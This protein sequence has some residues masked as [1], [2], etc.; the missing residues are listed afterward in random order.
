[1]KVGDRIGE[2]EVCSSA[3]RGARWLDLSATDPNGIIEAMWGVWVRPAWCPQCKGM[4]GATG[5]GGL[6]GNS[7]DPCH[8]GPY[9]V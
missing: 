3:E 9:H 1:M 5:D 8:F 7:W 6:D 4:G 2:W